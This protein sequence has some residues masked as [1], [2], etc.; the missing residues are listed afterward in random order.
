MN[1]KHILILLIALLGFFSLIVGY[2]Y[3]S[4]QERRKVIENEQWLL[5]DKDVVDN[6][7]K[8]MKEVLGRELY[9]D[10][11]TSCHR[12]KGTRNFNLRYAIEKLGEEYLGL[13]IRKE[14]SLLRVSDPWVI[15]IN[16]AYG[17]A[18]YDHVFEFSEVE[19]QQVISYLQ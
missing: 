18:G 2:S 14:D 8:L 3:Q 9:K 6:P 4:I 10:N 5:A 17:N 12:R 11:C 19:V 16:D 15:A 1:R 13:F 7:Q